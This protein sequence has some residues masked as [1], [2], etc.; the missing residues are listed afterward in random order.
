[1]VPRIPEFSGFRFQ[2]NGLAIR[3]VQL[4]FDEMVVEKVGA[5]NRFDDHA[6]HGRRCRRCDVA[7]PGQLEGESVTP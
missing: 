3:G 2:I 6:A 4:Q 7:N 5:E 1:V